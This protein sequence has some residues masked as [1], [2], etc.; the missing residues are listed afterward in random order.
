M[1]SCKESEKSFSPYLDGVL[2]RG[3]AAAL[4]E[5]L[6]ACPVCRGRLEATRALVRGLSLVARP[7][8]PPNLAGDIR[9]SLVIERA[10]RAASEPAPLHE[11][12]ALWLKLR[13]MP[14]AVGAVYSMVLFVAVFGA[15]RQQL[16]VLRNLA[17]A[18]YLEEGRPAFADGRGYDVTR[19]LSPDLAVAAR[20]PFTS[21]SPTLNPRGAL[22]KLTLA[23]ASDGRPE[24]DDMIV[25][26]DVYGNGTASLAEVVE[27]PRNRRMVEELQDALRKNPAFVPAS[28]DRRPQTMRV[29]FVLQKMNVGDGS[30]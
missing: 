25:V 17:E 16:I 18:R 29:V 20:A 9:A 22:A 23:P 21:E 6:G 8:P 15:L 7:A 28:L 4:D 13:L 1:I 30:F 2:P 10:A 27:P 24:D 26:A 5:H 14:Y 11:R 19:P 3:A 12:A